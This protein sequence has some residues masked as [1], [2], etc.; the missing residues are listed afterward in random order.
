MLTLTAATAGPRPPVPH[1][2]KPRSGAGDMHAAGERRTF[3]AGDELF[4]E[5]Q[6]ADFFYKVVSGTVRTSK[7]LSDARRQIDSF[8][9]QG[10]IFGFESA[11]DYSFTAE[12][13]EDTT[14]AVFRRSS[15]SSL[16]H[17]YPAFADQLMSAMVASLRRARDHM[18]L[19]G[20]RTPHEKIAMFLLDIAGRLQKGDRFDLPMRRAD[21]ADHL[22]LTKETV[23]RTLTQMERKGL[24]KLEAIGRTILLNDKASLRRL[25]A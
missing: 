1:V 16:A 23:S 9:L 5:G 22:G 8:H 12:A 7:L 11:S 25:N 2:M 17:D 18:L 4:A 13:V 6:P 24:I 21:I 3:V 15:F 20:R 14:V 19:L 10:D